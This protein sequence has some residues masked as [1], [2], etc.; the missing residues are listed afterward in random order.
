LEIVFQCPRSTCRHFFIARY[1]RSDVDIP[2]TATALGL[3]PGLRQFVFYES[4]PATP[5][6]PRL[7]AEVA[8]VSPLFVEIYSQAETADAFGLLQVA[9]VGYRKAL[10]FLVKDYCITITP[11]A[12]SAIRGAYLGACINQFVDSPQVKACAERAAWLGNDE[13]HYERRWDDF[14]IQNLKELILL[15]VKYLG[16]SKTLFAQEQAIG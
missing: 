3:S 15:T 8:Q 11:A 4:V 13:T 9:G 10:E 2:T 16:I 12:A 7:P 1:K 5:P 6:P 14:D